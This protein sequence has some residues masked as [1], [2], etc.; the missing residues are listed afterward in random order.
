MIAPPPDGNNLLLWINAIAIIVIGVRQQINAMA[1]KQRIQQM[2]D[3]VE[4]TQQK[5][6][7]I[8]NVST[9]GQV[10]IL[11]TRAAALRALAQLR[12]T[13]EDNLAAVQAEKDLQDYKSSQS[14]QRRSTDTPT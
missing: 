9:N 10:T 1:G 5:V 4:G 6:N 7:D 11:Q 12:N 8:H 2:Q 13:P 14:K 3:T